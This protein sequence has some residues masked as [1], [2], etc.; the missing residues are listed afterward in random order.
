MK[1]NNT[2]LEKYL[3]PLKITTLNSIQ[4]ASLEQYEPG[5]DMMLLAPTGTGKTLAFLLPVLDQLQ[6]GLEAVQ[7]LILVP[8]RELALQLEQ[9][10]KAMGTG[11]KINCCYGGHSFKTE[12]NNLQHP[13]AVLVGTPGRIADHL[14][15]R[16]FE[17]KNIHTIILDEFDKSLEL[18]F[19]EDMQSIIRRIPHLKSRILTSATEM[20]SIPAFV[21][22]SEPVVINHLAQH[23]APD[24][25]LVNI[26]TDSAGKLEMLFQL[27]CNIG[28]QPMLVFCNHREAVDRISDLLFERGIIHEVFHGGMDQEERERALLKFRNGSHYLL[29]TTDLAARGLDIPQIRHII[30]YQLPPKE[31]AFI[32]RNGRTARMNAS[33]TAYLVTTENDEIPA[34]ISKDINEMPLNAE[35][36][37]P[38]APEWETLFISAG[39]KSKINKVDIVG[40]FLKTGGL[41]KDDLGLIEVKD[42]YAYAAVKRNRVKAILPKVNNQKVKKQKLRIEVA[43]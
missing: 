12:T 43:R 29:V 33:G 15:R 16:S 42:Q 13:P 9:V 39:K 31:D 40:L 20:K 18:G 3:A 32:H 4:L 34:Y 19:E 25:E 23:P 1:I 22:F 5:K 21:E 14:N 24:I 8:S 35:A 27:I 7:V 6:P 30:H 36:P 17:T 37:V 26:P 2:D 10:F 11:F 41:A 38:E 28:S